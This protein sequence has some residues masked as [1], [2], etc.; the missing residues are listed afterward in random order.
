[1]NIGLACLLGLL[2]LGVED[3]V[4]LGEPW[5]VV[6]LEKVFVHF[7]ELFYLLLLG[8]NLLLQ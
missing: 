4:K 8:L 7:L 1:M 6:V 3:V 5:P 2:L